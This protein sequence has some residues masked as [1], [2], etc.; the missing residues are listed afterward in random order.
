MRCWPG[1]ESA[2]SS[3]QVQSAVG[4]LGCDDYGQNCINWSA[5]IIGGHGSLVA[6]PIIP[7]M[8]PCLY[9]LVLFNIGMICFDNETL[10]DK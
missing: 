8:V 5:R 3:A 7:D 6:T 10:N 4:V 1:A 9:I 2:G